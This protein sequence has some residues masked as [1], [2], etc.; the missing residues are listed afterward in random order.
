MRASHSALSVALSAVLCSAAADGGQTAGGQEQPIRTQSLSVSDNLYLM[1]GGGSNSLLLSGDDTDGVL[2][3]AK[4]AGTGRQIVEIAAAM[5][6]RPIGTVIYT[7]AHPDH[8]GGAADLRGPLVV[9]AHR[10]AA[11]DVN[12]TRAVA[13]RL[14]LGEGI[15]RID[16]F[17]F[18]AGHT[19]GD[20]VV[21]F[22]AK[23]IAHLGDLFPGK[24]VPTIDRAKGGSAVA[25]AETLTRALDSLQ[26]VTRVIPGHATP[27][28]GSPMGRWLTVRDLEEY[29]DFCRDLTE[30][31][32]QAFKAGRS[33]SDAAASLKL[34]DRY[35]AFSMENLQ[36]FVAAL[37]DELKP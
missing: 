15:D 27:P 14:T 24:V 12:A 34:A 37:Y 1:S 7:H 8:V 21:V 28:A 5:S 18:G 30:A 19:N 31:V 25:L 13:D 36:P 32:R 10:N 9:I 4:R 16:L 29:R 11:A 20:L 22:P 6:A 3:D 23:R 33:P 35:K 26:G 17:Y 2:V